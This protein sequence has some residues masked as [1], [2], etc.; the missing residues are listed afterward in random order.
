MHRTDQVAREATSFKLSEA[1][2]CDSWAFETCLVPE[3]KTQHYMA[4]RAPKRQNFMT[5]RHIN[6][7]ALDISVCKPYNCVH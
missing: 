3:L 5:C 2:C 6:E 1:R 4:K 7:F